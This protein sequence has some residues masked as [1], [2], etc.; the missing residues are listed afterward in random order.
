MGHA[1]LTTG[2]APV[3]CVVVLPTGPTVMS[4]SNWTLPASCRAVGSARQRAIHAASDPRLWSSCHLRWSPSTGQAQKPPPSR[5]ARNGQLQQSSL[6]RWTP[7]H[8]ESPPRLSVVFMSVLSASSLCRVADSCASRWSTWSLYARPDVW[9]SSTSSSMFSSTAVVHFF[10]R[11]YNR[12]T[13]M[14]TILLWHAVVRLLM[15]N[16]MTFSTVRRSTFK[17]SMSP[18]RATETLQFSADHID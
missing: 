17:F 1:P 9:S 12:T 16:L 11:R 8:P 2:S 6:V 10:L 13:D 18:L 7:A 5:P 4:L 3:E 14:R 15:S